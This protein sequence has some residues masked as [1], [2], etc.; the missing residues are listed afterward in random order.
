MYINKHLN[1]KERGVMFIQSVYNLVMLPN[2]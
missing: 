1:Q 2:I